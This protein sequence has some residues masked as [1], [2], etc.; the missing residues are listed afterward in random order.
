MEACQEAEKLGW[1]GEDC[2]GGGGQK[3]TGSWQDQE[4]NYTEQIR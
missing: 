3:V 4:I 2:G 1:G